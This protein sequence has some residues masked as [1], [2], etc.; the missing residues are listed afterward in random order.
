LA[1]LCRDPFLTFRAAVAHPI[2]IATGCCMKLAA[3]ATPRLARPCR[4]PLFSTSKDLF[5]PD[6]KKSHPLYQPHLNES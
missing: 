5:V 2:F 4:D 3:G 1:R 6:L